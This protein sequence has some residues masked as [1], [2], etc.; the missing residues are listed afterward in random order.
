M[1]LQ[2]KIQLMKTLRLNTEVLATTDIKQQLESLE[3]TTQAIQQRS[4]SNRN[5]IR[6]LNSG[7]LNLDDYV[8]YSFNSIDNQINEL[9]KNVKRLADNNNR[10]WWLWCITAAFTFTAVTFTSIMCFL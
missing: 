2:T 8:N 9:Q 7:L 5:K 6:D 4:I 10:L 1:S 3:K